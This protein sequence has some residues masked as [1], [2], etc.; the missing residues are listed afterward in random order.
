MYRM[1]MTGRGWR[2]A[3]CAGPWYRRKAP[4]P[5]P[6]QITKPQEEVAEMAERKRWYMITISRD[7]E[8][9]YCTKCFQYGNEAWLSWTED[10][11][12]A[13]LFVSAKE[14]WWM[15]FAYKRNTKEEYRFWKPDVMMKT[16]AQHEAVAAGQKKAP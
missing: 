4:E 13:S 6:E 5:E 10:R 1:Q 14:A 9:L 15:W 2:L 11:E 16:A 8:T 3:P 12:K 7:G